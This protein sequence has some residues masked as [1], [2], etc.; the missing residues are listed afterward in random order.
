MSQKLFISMYCIILVLASVLY[1]SLG[2]PVGK[3]IYPSIFVVWCILIVMCAYIMKSA[4]NNNKLK[5]SHRKL[6]K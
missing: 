5:N 3:F 4:S 1:V 2:F 6:E